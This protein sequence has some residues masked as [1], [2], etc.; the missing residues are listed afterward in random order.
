MIK[1]GFISIAL[2]IATIL[3]TATMKASHHS[4]HY[5]EFPS[6]LI[7]DQTWMTHNLSID[8]F[9]NG[10]P[11]PEARTK[12][13]WNQAASKKKPAWCYYN[14]D[15]TNALKYGKLYNF[16]AVSDPRG[17]AP[18][19]WRIPTEKDWYQLTAFLNGKTAACYKMKST[20]G[21]MDEGNGS[22]STGFTALPG[23]SRDITLINTNNGFSGLGQFGFWW[24]SVKTRTNEV[25]VFS[26]SRRNEAL[27]F[28][29]ADQQEGLSVRCIR[30]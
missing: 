20:S 3:F 10:D 30:E 11:I 7:G 27:F 14:N 16:Y 22:N 8:T 18:A 1:N 28:T 6:I 12:K 5:Q 19:G 17:L 2:F 29:F 15:S 24:S 23:G 4:D 13:E 25:Y 21:W 9:R 26:L